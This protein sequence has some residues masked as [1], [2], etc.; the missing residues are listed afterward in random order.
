MS[1]RGWGASF[2][3][4]FDTY[5]AKGGGSIFVSLTV[6]F[7]A[8]LLLIALMRGLLLWL[9]PVDVL[10][11]EHEG[12]FFLNL[13]ITFLQLTDPGNMAQDIGSSG[14]YKFTAILAGL[15]GTIML[16]ALIAFIT[17]ALDQKLAALKR[18]RSKVIE[19]E[20]SLI[21]GW[22]EQRVVEILR[23]LILANES[24]RDECVVVLGDEDKEEMDDLLRMRLPDTKSTRLVTRSGDVSSLPNLDMVSV[25]TCR[26]VIII[27]SCED[28]AGQREKDAS[29]AKTMQTILA[30]TSM[31]PDDD[32]LV[33]VAEIFNPTY[34]EV[35][36]H[37]FSDNVV[38]VDTKDVLAKIMV[39]TSR[40]VGLSVVYNEILSFDGCEMYFCDAAW[41]GI[42]FRALPYRFPDGIP[43]GVRQAGGELLLNP[44]VDYVMK[45]DDAVLILADDD[46]TISF[47][48]QR[49]AEPTELPLAT[50]RLEQQK[51]EELLLGWS[52]KAPVILEQYADY[53]MDGSRVDVMLSDPDEAIVK[54]IEAVDAVLQGLDVRLI[55]SNRL[56]ADDLIKVE[57][58]KYNNIII[59]A[60]DSSEDN[61][62]QVDSE[63]IVTL[64][65]LRE[66]F[67][68][69]AA[70]SAKPHPPLR[71]LS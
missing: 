41:G 71:S 5:M 39:Q 43:M 66:I 53:V 33:I 44:P 49:V 38:T 50:G 47:E 70:E 9:F 2:R 36:E 26:S 12:G 27:G 58:F 24:E 14:A 61:A 40:S 69:H 54:E 68:A 8:I 17:T 10:A 3:Y 65:L 13:Y 29:D 37:T 46:S 19:N 55:R 60:A 59:L 34:R 4:R 7:L 23:E 20:H 35:V 1:E 48:S 22:N 6:V 52:D 42:E 67:R 32:D 21:L 28:S 18:G 25:E 57:P 51:E 56:H 64:L 16:S 63:N 45:D 11:M 15:S 31:R 30:V 62:Q